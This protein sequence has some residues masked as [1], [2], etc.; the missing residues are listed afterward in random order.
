[1]F[2]PSRQPGK[3]WG[4]AGLQ[5]S[6]VW[7]VFYELLYANPL[8]HGAC[9]WNSDNYVEKVVLSIYLAS[10]NCEPWGFI[11][12]GIIL[13]MVYSQQ[14]VPKS[15]FCGSFSFSP[16]HIFSF[17][18]CLS[19]MLFRVWGPHTY[20]LASLAC[21]RKPT[22]ISLFGK[23]IN[24]ACFQIRAKMKALFGGFLTSF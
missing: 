24:H 2:S 1:M 19:L 3:F 10:L 13:R 5:W 21:R 7:E 17:S 12:H 15:R 23:K 6:V 14:L 4:G 8:L 11:M 16:P 18:I 22:R 20:L 9:L